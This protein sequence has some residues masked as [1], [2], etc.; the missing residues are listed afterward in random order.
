MTAAPESSVPRD[1]ILDLATMEEL[2]SLDDGATGLVAEMAGLFQ[3]D[4]PLRIAQLKEAC[5]TGDHQ[6]AGE[7]A[8][9]LKG[10]AGTLG[11]VRLRN[12]AGEAER[13]ARQ[14]DLPGIQQLIPALEA[15]Y[16]IFI[17]TL[18][19]FIRERS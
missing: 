15:S 7:S 1:E 11:A 10:A 3:E 4:G 18:E 5:E 17:E 6:A 8:H 14:Q 9:A 12:V 13:L 16:P 2:L 19:A